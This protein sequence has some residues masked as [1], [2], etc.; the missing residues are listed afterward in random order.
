MGNKILAIDDYQEVHSLADSLQE[1]FDY[2]TENYGSSFEIIIFYELGNEIKA[3]LKV[4]VIST[5]KVVKGEK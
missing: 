3:E 2:L 5:N 4:E 1:A